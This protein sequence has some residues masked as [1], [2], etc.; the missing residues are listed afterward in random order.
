MEKVITD[1][2]AVQKSEQ[3]QASTGTAISN[4][5]SANSSRS[6]ASGRRSGASNSLSPSPNVTAS[7]KVQQLADI[8]SKI[9]AA[10]AM[11]DVDRV[12][13]LMLQRAALVL[14]LES[15]ASVDVIQRSDGS[16]RVRTTEGR[17]LVDSRNATDGGRTAEVLPPPPP[18]ETRETIAARDFAVASFSEAQGSAKASSP[19]VQASNDSAPSF[20][21]R[22]APLPDSGIPAV[23]RV[24]HLKSKVEVLVQVEAAMASAEA[25]LSALETHQGDI[26]SLI[27]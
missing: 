22:P 7:I 20:A 23:D 26:D 5:A 17:V 4:K 3:T 19:T 18:I 27:G 25:Q 10:N 9:Q 12:D 1:G 6:I 16:I 2:T 8:N 21:A 15:L 13:S 14:E 24:A 11:N